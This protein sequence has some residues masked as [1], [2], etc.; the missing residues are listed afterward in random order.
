MRWVRGQKDDR[1]PAI[2]GASLTRLHDTCTAT[3]T[4]GSNNQKRIALENFQTS[5]S[6]QTSTNF[7]KVDD[8]FEG[9]TVLYGGNGEDIDIDICAV[10]G[11]DGHAFDTWMAGKKMWLRDHLPNEFP[12]SRIMTFGYNSNLTDIKSINNNLPNF[13]DA[14]I[15]KLKYIRTSNE[16][17]RRPVLLICHSMGGL[18]G[19]LAVTRHWR[20]QGK[21]VKYAST[22]FGH[23]GLLFLSTPHF[24]SDMA[25]ISEFFLNVA[26]S[27]FGVRRKLVEEL[28]TSNPSVQDVID[29]WR[30]MNPQPIIRCLCETDLTK[31]SLGDKQIVTAVS[32]GFMGVTAQP[33]PGTNHS[34]VCR[35]ETKF[36]R[37]W[38]EVLNSLKEIREELLYQSTEVVEHVRDTYIPGRT[39]ISA[40][41]FPPQGKHFYNEIH[42]QPSTGFVGR[43]NLLNDIRRMLENNSGGRIALTGMAGAGKTE[44]LLQLAEAYRDSRD[45]FLFPSSTDKELCNAMQDVAIMMGHDLME[46]GRNLQRWNNLKPEHQERMLMRWIESRPVSSPCLIILDDLGD[47]RQRASGASQNTTTVL[48]STRDPVKSAHTGFEVMPVSQ[49]DIDDMVLLFRSRAAQAG[50]LSILD[51]HYDQDL[52][53]LAQRFECHAFG[54]CAASTFLSHLRRANPLIPEERFLKA[55]FAELEGFVAKDHG[56]LLTVTLSEHGNL[57]IMKLYRDTL[58]RLESCVPWQNFL[59]LMAFTQPAPFF[60]N[61]QQNLNIFDFWTKV[62][63]RFDNTAIRFPQPILADTLKMGAGE[64]GEMLHAF[65]QASLGIRSRELTLIPA[66]WRACVIQDCEDSKRESWL[67]QIIH[68]SHNVNHILGHGA[69][70]SLAPY[71]RNCFDIAEQFN[72]PRE[73]L[74]AF[75][76]IDS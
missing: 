45:V 65:E 71:V 24:G 60:P 32:A 53:I 61:A 55:F 31:T 41:S 2:W 48:V 18:V 44:I 62:D 12:K 69:D 58:S 33:V 15:E 36:E 56:G 29:D 68:L 50:L 42:R 14:L 37:G 16:E 39:P 21:G 66:L 35:F 3:V 46:D 59:E 40:P 27:A 67:Q 73:R 52:K 7:Q 23:Y 19:R 64:R 1:E 11:M 43:V 75:E 38:A 25:N 72:I 26:S 70:K 9:L 30:T 47:E 4:F 17:Q 6:F 13:A 28:K 22:K 74:K 34:T 10:H 5:T 8:E 57:S 63:E 49:L 51:N 76:L 20:W 54:A